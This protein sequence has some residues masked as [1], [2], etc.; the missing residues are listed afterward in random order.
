MEIKIYI[1]VLLAFN[2]LLNYLVLCITG[3][4]LKIRVKKRRLF[5]ASFLGALYAVLSFFAPDSYV[6]SLFF[7]LLAGA[8]MALFAFKPARLCVFIKYLCAFYATVFVLGGMAFAFFYFSGSAA[9]LGAVY[10]N[11]TLYINLPM[12]LLLPLCLLCYVLLNVTFCVGKKLSARNKEIYKIRFLYCGNSYTLHAYYDSGN[13]LTEKK[14][15]KGVIIAE[16]ESVR[17]LFPRTAF[18]ELLKRQD[19]ISI[20]YRTL[21]GKSV[22]PAFLPDE[23]YI[24]GRRRT[25]RITPFYIGL[26]NQTLDYYHKWDAVLP[27]SFKGEESYEKHMDS[28]IAERRQAAGLSHY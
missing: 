2:V 10:R 1:D 20:S 26:V 21:Q 25:C 17:R 13:L 3:S 12:S 18:S 6:Y 22:L 4:L 19:I 7:K 16:W 28:P 8:L 9:S 27:H 24:E 14:S 5:L 15:G 23:M 11:G